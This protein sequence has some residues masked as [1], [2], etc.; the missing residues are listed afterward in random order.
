M[1][2]ASTLFYPPRKF[3]LPFASGFVLHNGSDV[4]VMREERKTSHVTS[5]L[6]RREQE[7]APAVDVWAWP[8][9]RG[10]KDLFY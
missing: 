1:F 6:I 4:A 9:A 3:T 10:Q 2:I 7:P 5:G 8:V